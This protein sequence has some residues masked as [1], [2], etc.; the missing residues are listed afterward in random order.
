MSKSVRLD[1][2]I[3]AGLGGNDYAIFEF[4]SNGGI[5]IS[6]QDYRYN[7][8]DRPSLISV[9]KTTFID[10]IE[11]LGFVVQEKSLEDILGDHLGLGTDSFI[12]HL[13]DAGYKIVPK[14]D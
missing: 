13:E 4:D 3:L 7:K 8:D 14:E 5:I 10:A 9:S 1:D 6:V 2:T 12:E 11:Q